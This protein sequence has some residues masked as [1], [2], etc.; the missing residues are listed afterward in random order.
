LE[1]KDQSRDGGRKVKAWNGSSPMELPQR[2]QNVGSA[3]GDVGKKKKNEISEP[4]QN[5]EEALFWIDATKNFN[6][7]GGMQIKLGG[8]G[9]QNAIKSYNFI[10]KTVGCS[11]QAL[12]RGV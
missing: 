11:K 2:K 10:E 5:V 1:V 12:P 4:C 3:Q 8:G 6:F 9:I 7:I